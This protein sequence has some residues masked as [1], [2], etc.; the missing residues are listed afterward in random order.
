MKLGYAKNLSEAITMAE[1]V[2][3]KEHHRVII[4]DGVSVVVEE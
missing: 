2:V 1:E 4:P 3:G